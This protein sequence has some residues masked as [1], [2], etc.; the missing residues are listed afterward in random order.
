MSGPRV[1]WTDRQHVLGVD[2]SHYDYDAGLRANDFATL[3]HQGVRFVI[4]KAAQGTNYGAGYTDTVQEFVKGARQH[5]M[6]IGFYHYMDRTD[7]RA[8]A[9]NFINTLKKQLGSFPQDAFFAFDMEWNYGARPR[10]ATPFIR[11]FRRQYPKAR[12]LLYTAPGYWAGIGN[13]QVYDTWFKRWGVELWNADWRYARKE[14]IA[15][16]FR[17]S[18]GGYKYA[19]VWQHTKPSHAGPDFRKLDTNLAS[20]SFNEMKA[21]IL[22]GD[23]NGGDIPCPEGYHRVNGNCVPKPC[24]D[25]YHRDALGVCVPGTDD[26]PNPGPGS[27]PWTEPWFDEAAHSQMFYEGTKAGTAVGTSILLLGGLVIVGLGIA[28]YAMK[29]GGKLNPIIDMGEKD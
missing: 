24:P 6:L 12:L 2:L 27:D 21:W 13:P 8:Q 10:N 26:N 1:V 16:K 25:G 11:E 17:V 29:S 3:Q 23:G 28:Y 5:D 22:G 14:I 4:I 19:R 7:G 15:K 9:I 20:M 18:Y